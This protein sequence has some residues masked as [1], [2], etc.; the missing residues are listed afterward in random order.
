MRWFYHFVT[1]TIIVFSVPKHL[2]LSFL[3]MVICIEIKSL[4][5]F[6][7]YVIQLKKISISNKGIKNIFLMNLS[8]YPQI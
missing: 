2:I 1:I 7:F 4:W 3:K 6:I 5:Y 8:I